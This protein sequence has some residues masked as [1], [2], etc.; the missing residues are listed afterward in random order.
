ME[1][2][3]VVGAG[4]IGG[5]VARRLAAR[6]YRV[7]VVTRSGSGPAG[8]ERIAADAA[9]AEVMARLAVGAVAIYNCA[10]PPYHRWSTDWP[11]IAH[12]LQGAAERAGAVLVTISNLYGYG[13]ARGSLGVAAYDEL[14]PMTAATPLAATGSKGKVRA[15]MWTEA[16]QAHRDGRLR[17]VEVRASD[18]I[19]PGAASVIGERFV[20]RVL[21]GKNA[22]VL[23][24][25]DRL[26][27]WSFTEDVAA[28]A[29]VAGSDP[30]AWGQAW[31]APSNAPRTQR[32]VA[33][34]MARAAG[35]RPPRLRPL[36]SALLAGLGSVSP[37]MR[38]L[39]ETEYQF[40]DDF[41]M[42]SSTATM[43]FGLT[44]TPWDTVLAATLRSYGWN[45]VPG[46]PSTAPASIDTPAR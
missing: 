28:M 23:G 24:R 31:H 46:L 8:V 29:V 38:E 21:R 6:G 5:S 18:Y 26:H 2:H 15:R 11:P 32:A 17:A 33:E 44:P 14:H 7:L 10:N 27:T 37:L 30:R 13:P 45:G 41:I 12:S 43:T 22:V 25:T 19:G 35:A 16:L 3:L 34:D 39:R 9:D 1:F 40:R 20:P 4:A 42:D 36:P